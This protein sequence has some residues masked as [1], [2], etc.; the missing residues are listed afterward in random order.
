MIVQNRRAGVTLTEALIAVFIMA[1]GLLALLSLFPV[2]ALQMAQAVRNER[3]AQVANNPDSTARI[4]WRQGWSAAST[5]EILP[6]YYA[7]QNEPFL[8]ALDNPWSHEWPI[9]APT[10][11]TAGPQVMA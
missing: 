3:A 10:P 2:G 8:R 7:M 1:I 4:M 5:N 9:L 11:A 6:D